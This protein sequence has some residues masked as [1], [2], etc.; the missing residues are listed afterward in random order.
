LFS[1]IVI[2]G[3]QYILRLIVFLHSTNRKELVEK[4]LLLRGS[5]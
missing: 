3:V 4:F 1:E 5:F 2:F